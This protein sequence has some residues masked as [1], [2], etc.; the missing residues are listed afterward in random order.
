MTEPHA[1]SDVDDGIVD[2]EAEK[3]AETSA[4]S[5]RS[6]VRTAI[7]VGAAVVLA[8]TG[9]CVGLA[10]QVYREHKTA[11]T[12]TMLV[13]AARQA[14]VNLTTVDYTRAEADVQRILDSATGAFL[15]DFRARSAPFIDVVRKAE[16]KSEGTVT[17]AGLESVDG[18]EGRVLV[19]V[20]V[21]TSTQGKQDA[22]P[23]YWRMRLTVDRKG[24]VAKVSRVDFVA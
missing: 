18:D 9:L 17:E 22:Q 3:S 2:T 8:L 6:S 24:D 16:S 21:R 19:A 10:S 15:D 13:Q 1:D 5:P 14:A 11:E 12:R 7:A 23:R 20:T 4:E